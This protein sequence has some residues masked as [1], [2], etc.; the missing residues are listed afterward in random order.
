MSYSHTY[1][2]DL[3]QLGVDFEVVVEYRTYKGFA[4]SNE[5]PP[6]EEGFEV[7][8]IKC[9]QLG[10]LM[11]IYNMGETFADDVNDRIATEHEK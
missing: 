7:T 8:S 11:E 2:A 3:G 10:C 4:G 6:E 9:F 1:Y 5:E